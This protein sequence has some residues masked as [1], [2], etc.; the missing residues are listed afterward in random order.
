M[1]TKLYSEILKGRNHLGD[2]AI[3]GTIILKL[4]LKK[5]DVRVAPDSVCASVAGFVRTQ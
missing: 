3:D 1:H 2:P 4:I 5:Q